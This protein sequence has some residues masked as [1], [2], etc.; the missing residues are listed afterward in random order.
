VAAFYR[1]KLKAMAEGKQL[2]DMSSNDGA[3]L[4]LVDDKAKSTIQVNVGKADKGSDIVI[5]ASRSGAK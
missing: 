3:T 2:M 1:D 5:V 4:S